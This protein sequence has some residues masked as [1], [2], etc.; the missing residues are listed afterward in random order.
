VAT[1]RPPSGARELTG[2]SMMRDPGDER[3]EEPKS[4]PPASGPANDLNSGVPVRERRD[5]LSSR[6]AGSTG[7]A[8]DDADYPAYTMGRAA[9][10][11][12]VTAGFLRA[13][14][15][16]GLLAPQRSAGRHRRYSRH[17]LDL[18]ARARSL[19]TEG[20][21]LAAAARI[22]ALEEEL[23]DARRQI[24][25][26]QATGRGAHRAPAGGGDRT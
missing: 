19:V 1:R 12:G 25:D 3:R 21:S 17:E 23:A 11:L 5:P 8:F 14:G 7:G 15:E 22:I 16:V 4:R 10:M 20:A 9:E 6:V 18:A 13:L 24:A 2:V 26:L